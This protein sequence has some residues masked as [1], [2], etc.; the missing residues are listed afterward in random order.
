MEIRES[1]PTQPP[2]PRPGDGKL[3]PLDL[4]GVEPTDDGRGWKLTVQPMIPGTVLVPPINFGDG[5]QSSELRVVVPRTTP[6]QAPWMGIGGGQGD[7]I[8][9]V[10]FPWAWASLLLLPLLSIGGWIGRRWRRTAPGRVRHRARSLFAH[11]W[12]PHDT[13][14]ETLDAV[15][16]AGRDL[17]AAHFGEEARSWGPREF[18]EQNLEAWALWSQSLDSARFALRSPPFPP[19]AELL[20]LLEQRP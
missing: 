8:P 12:P 14:R 7:I 16:A 5:R 4:R 18:R 9:A 2:L 3:G 13:D 19:L 6:Y 20:K 11:N 17:L 1:D 15:H 10:P